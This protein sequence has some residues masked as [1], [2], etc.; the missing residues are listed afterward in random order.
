MFWNWPANYTYGKLSLWNKN[1]ISSILNS[2]SFQIMIHFIQLSDC[3]I[4][5]LFLHICFQNPKFWDSIF[6]VFWKSSCFL[7]YHH[8]CKI[9]LHCLFC[10]DWLIL[11][12]SLNSVLT[13]SC[14]FWKFF[15]S[16]SCQLTHTKKIHL[17]TNIDLS[18]IQKLSNLIRN[19]IRIRHQN[20]TYNV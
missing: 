2:K 8:E 13:D 3:L 20:K 9:I 6:E 5:P 7:L 15:E 14:I 12:Q 16:E 4:F 17:E 19:Q 18:R 1:C 11:I 10:F